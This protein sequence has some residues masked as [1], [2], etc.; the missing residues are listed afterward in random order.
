METRKLLNGTLDEQAL[1]LI[2]RSWSVDQGITMRYGFDAALA[3]SNIAYWYLSKKAK[4]ENC[5]DGTYWTYMPISRL[6]K[7]YN[8]TTRNKMQAA[9]KKLV[10]EGVLLEGNYNKK[11][12][13][14]T[15]WY[16]VNEKHPLAV[17]YL[18]SL[19]HKAKKNI[20]TIAPNMHRHVAEIQQQPAGIKQG[21]TENQQPLTENQQ[22]IPNN[23][24]NSITNNISNKGTIGVQKKKKYTGLFDMSMLEEVCSC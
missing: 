22:A 1:A 9:M 4:Q 5:F 17:A 12:G 2:G 11:A 20:K 7:E 21:F 15:K 16:A 13:D 3:L 18:E 6:L 23:N 14:N 8:C 10:E 19:T 24:T